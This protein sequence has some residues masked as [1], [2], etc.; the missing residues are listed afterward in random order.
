MLPLIVVFVDCIR[1]RFH[2]KGEGTQPIQ[3]ALI[4]VLY[5]KENL[6]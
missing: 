6:L 4:V 5:E 2:Q 1:G 3:N